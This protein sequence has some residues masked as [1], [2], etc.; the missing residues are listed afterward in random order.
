M[1]ERSD[2][3]PKISQEIQKFVRERVNFLCEYC[4]TDERWQLVRFTIG[5][6]VPIAKGGSRDPSN[7]ALPVFIAIAENPTFKQFSIK[8][9]NL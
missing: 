6:I 1:Q 3:P 8:S 5:H 7:L 9:P 4:H 2:L